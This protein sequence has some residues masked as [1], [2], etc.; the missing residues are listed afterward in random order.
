M[1]RVPCEE[2]LAPGAGLGAPDLGGKLCA[3]C[4]G[5]R[6]GRWGLHGPFSPPGT[7]ILGELSN[8][9]HARCRE[10]CRSAA[11][12]QGKPALRTIPQNDQEGPYPGGAQGTRVRMNTS[13]SHSFNPHMWLQGKEKGSL[14]ELWHYQLRGIP[15]AWEKAAPRL[16][17]PYVCRAEQQLVSGWGQRG[18][19]W[20]APDKQQASRVVAGWAQWE[21]QTGR[22]HRP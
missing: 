6:G 15:T 21:G 1:T 22:R 9:E 5:Y 18:S 17:V 4:S 12:N 11:S 16:A 2:D 14:Y 13:V 20:G 10:R 7:D 19:S 8:L 3:P